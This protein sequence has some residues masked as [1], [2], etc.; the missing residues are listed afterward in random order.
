[1]LHI[2]DTWQHGGVFDVPVLMWCYRIH[3]HALPY[4]KRDATMPRV[5]SYDINRT[6]RRRWLR[7]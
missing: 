5:V 7:T 6:P 4:V 2:V 1:M 3:T